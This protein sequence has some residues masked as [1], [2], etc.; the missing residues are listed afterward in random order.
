MDKE[1]YPQSFVRAPKEPY[2]LEKWNNTAIKVRIASREYR[3]Y[4]LDQIVDHLTNNWDYQERES[5]KRWLDHKVKRGQNNMTMQK[6]AYDFG[7]TQK[8]EKLQELK[9]KLRS[10]VSSAERLLNKMMDEGLLG[11]NTEKALYISRILQ[12]L[13]EEINLLQR[14]EMIQAR[15]QRA[16][17]IIRKAGLIEIAEHLDENVILVANFDKIPLI[18]TAQQDVGSVLEA[19]KEEL[20]LFN[21]GIHLRKMMAISSQL[22]DMGYHSESE[23]VVEI[24]KKEL[25]GLDSIHKKLVDVYTAIGQ[26]PRQR[27][28]GPTIPAKPQVNRREKPEGMGQPTQPRIESAPRV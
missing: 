10:R 22:E 21:Y 17:K 23:M 16:S 11:S 4:G 7:A 1:A 6:V 27:T 26:I 5:F 28:Q 19:I 9:K 3:E 12:K 24:I 15:N 8:D 25:D 14:P 20:D 13:K 2:D 18:K